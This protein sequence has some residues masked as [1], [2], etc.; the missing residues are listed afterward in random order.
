MNK[1]KN[2]VSDEE[3]H[4][5]DEFFCLIAH[6]GKQVFYDLNNKSMKI[7]VDSFHLINWRPRAPEWVE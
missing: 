4:S 7:T 2:I 3:L 6:F 5:Y 1:I